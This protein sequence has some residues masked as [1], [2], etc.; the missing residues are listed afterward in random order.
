M[1]AP[2]PSRALLS[3][4]DGILP[5][6]TAYGVAADGSM[7]QLAPLNA[8]NINEDNFMPMPAKMVKR[9]RQSRVKHSQA[10]SSYVGE[11][12]GKHMVRHTHCGGVWGDCGD[13]S[14]HPDLFSEVSDNHSFGSPCSA[15]AATNE[16]RVGRALPTVGSTKRAVGMHRDAVRGNGSRWR[17]ARAGRRCRWRCARLSYN[18]ATAG[19]S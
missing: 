9:A 16:A 13:H 2:V 1:H 8:F 10:T 12:G 17:S 6:S 11:S 15:Y 7:Y 19:S 5:S 3:A 4:A 14:S 18:I